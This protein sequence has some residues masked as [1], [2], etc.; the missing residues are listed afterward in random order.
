MSESFFSPLPYPSLAA[1]HDIREI[2]GPSH[3]TKGQGAQGKVFR[4]S[5][6]LASVHTQ[7]ILIHSF[8][9]EPSL[10]GWGGHQLSSR[11]TLGVLLLWGVL[12]QFIGNQ[13]HPSCLGPFLGCHPSGSSKKPFR[14]ELWY[15][16]ILGKGP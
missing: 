11:L 15:Q 12:F 5:L 4:A 10:P 2:S 3:G 16:T 7:Y 8:K 13:L 6:L 9:V 1:L 14:G